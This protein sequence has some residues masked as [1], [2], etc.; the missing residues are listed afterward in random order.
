MSIAGMHLAS[1]LHIPGFHMQEWRGHRK[2]LTIH[3]LGRL[4]FWSG[5]GAGILFAMLCYL[6]LAGVRDATA[7]IIIELGYGHP[8]L[9]LSQANASFQNPFGYPPTVRYAQNLFTAAIAV[10]FA[11]GITISIWLTHRGWQESSRIRRRRYL[12]IA[13][14]S[15]WSWLILWVLLKIGQAYWQYVI[16]STYSSNQVPE[17]DFLRD[18]GSLLVLLIVVMFLEHWK[19][20]RLVYRCGRWQLIAAIISLALAL[21]LALI[22]PL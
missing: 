19:T 8:A 17:L 5:L 16:S 7:I 6:F 18:Y 14:L 3:E 9:A 21:F 22:Q 10:V 4:R 20:L 13:W 1:K 11:Q 2:L 15:A 12:T